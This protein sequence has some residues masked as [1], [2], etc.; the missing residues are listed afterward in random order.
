LKPLVVDHDAAPP[1]FGRDPPVA[2]APPAF[3]GDLLNRRARSR[4]PESRFRRMTG[5][6]LCGAAL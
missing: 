5:W 3:D 4:R 2:I 6:M 1:Q